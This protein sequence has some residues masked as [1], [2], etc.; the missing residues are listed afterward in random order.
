MKKREQGV[1]T[2]EASIV[3]TL[4]ILFILFLFSFARVYSAQSMV[5]HAVLQSADAIALES[6]LREETLTG[7]EADVTE[8]AN[9]FM[10][11]TSIS[12]DNYTSLRSA[13]VPKIA[14]EKFVYAIGKNETEA[15]EKLKRLGVKNGL[16]GVDF[17]ASKIDL[18]NDDVIVYAN[19]TIE[20]QF[21]VFGMNEIPVTKA[22]KSKTFGDILFGIETVPDD[23]IMGSASGGGN[24]KFGTTI[25]ISATPCYGYKFTKWAD[26][27]TENPRTVT[28]T[29]AKTYVAMFEP[30][31]FGVNLVSTPEVGGSTSGGGIYRYLDSATITANPAMGYHFTKWSIYGHKDRTTKTDNNQTSTVNVDQSYTCTA[32]F[33][34]NKYTVKVETSGTTAGNAYIVYNSS[35]KS[36]IEALYQANFK[37]SAPKLAGYEFLG[38]KEKGSDSYFNTNPSISMTVPAK[39]VTY[40]ACYKS[41]ICT[42]RFYNGDVLYKTRTV[43]AGDSLG[44]NMPP[45]P[46]IQGKKFGGW[47]NFNDGTPVY[48]D[49]S[50]YSSWSQCNSHVWGRCGVT[51]TGTR[52]AYLS[53]HNKSHMTQYYQCEVCVECGAFSYGTCSRYCINDKLDR[54]KI[55]RV[56]LCYQNEVC[57]D[58]WNKIY[59]YP[60]RVF[61]IHDEIG[62]P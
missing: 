16:A 11:T 20:M 61:N 56:H 31:Q 39:N 54:S 17:S 35:N 48:T 24:Y 32:H 25:Q 41:T 3:L 4:C 22:A 45:N 55:G 44:T 13:D 19:Y 58:Y 46:F 27:S 12:A 21:S 15:D 51:H 62:Y 6:H 23:P 50:V 1:L 43:N 59:P 42:V 60:L 36:S 38:W 9:R 57:E 33:D 5:S 53:G 28:V 7:S 14:K 29:G 52:S 34:K 49:M 2:V 18:G 26:G 30:D 10:G 37:L 8:L 47:I 40:V